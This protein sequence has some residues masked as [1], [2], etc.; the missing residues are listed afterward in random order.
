[1]VSAQ[2]GTHYNI[3]PEVVSNMTNFLQQQVRYEA[4]STTTIPQEDSLSPLD[5]NYEWFK[6]H[7][8]VGIGYEI[9][10]MTPPN[11][12]FASERLEKSTPVVFSNISMSY[13]E[14]R[15]VQQDR[16]NLNARLADHAI[17]MARRQDILTYVGDSKHGVDAFSGIGTEFTTQ[18]D[19]TT[20]TLA[21]TSLAVAIDQLKASLKYSS[22]IGPEST[23]ILEVNPNVWAIAD[24]ATSATESQ[25]ALMVLNRKLKDSFSEASRVVSNHYLD[26]TAVINANGVLTSLT[27]GTTNA[28][29][30][31]QDPRIVKVVNSG[32]ETRVSPLDQTRGITFQPIK[33]TRRIDV[34]TLGIL[35]ETAVKIA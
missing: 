35:K 7:D 22:L 12:D 4:L 24:G 15:R 3:N 5:K 25:N 19:V 9:D 17:I 29:L 30:Y 27:I 23:V 28:M 34:E 21:E 33:R 31:V 20:P 10:V 18:L 6:A 32:M 16:Y 26:A 13:D 11:S 2:L 1:M 14:W 8:N